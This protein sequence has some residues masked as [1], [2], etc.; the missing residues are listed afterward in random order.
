[1]NLHALLRLAAIAS[2]SL[3]SAC[4]LLESQ[5]ATEPQTPTEP[6]TQIEAPAP[7]LLDQARAGDLDS[8][9]QLGSRYFVGQPEKDLKKAEYWWK[10]AADKGHPMAGV[11][12][13]YLYT[14]RDAP[15]LANQREMLRYLNQ[16]AA[17]N[18]AMAQH[19]LGSLYLRGEGGLTRDPDQ[20]N[21]LYQ[22]AC[23]QGFE[24]SC[25]MLGKQ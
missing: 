12:L 21:R 20:A 22:A 25:K 16:A 24:D 19:I 13:A 5:P 8:Q 7:S 11:S 15:E 6:K 14:G 2:L 10:L 23:N 9:F 17:A 1:M 18:N 3:L 4:S